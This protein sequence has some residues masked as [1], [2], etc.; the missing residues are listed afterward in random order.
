[1][2]RNVIFCLHTFVVAIVQ[3]YLPLNICHVIGCTAPIFTFVTNYLINSIKT[4]KNQ[5]IGVAITFI[6][7]CLVVNGSLIYSMFFEDYSFYSKF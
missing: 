4:T 3:F 1:M 6:G 7:L 5:I 2:V